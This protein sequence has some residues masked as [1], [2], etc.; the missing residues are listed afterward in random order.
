MINFRFTKSTW[1]KHQQSD[2]SFY[3]RFNRAWVNF[4]ENEVEAVKSEK[5]KVNSEKFNT[6][7]L[8]FHF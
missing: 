7:S 4:Q 1:P 5:L 3:K 2:P 8:T 6:S